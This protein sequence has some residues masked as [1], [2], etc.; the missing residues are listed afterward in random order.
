MKIYLGGFP[1][2]E[3]DCEIGDVLEELKRY[4]EAGELE[5]GKAFVGIENEKHHILNIV[6]LKNEEFG[7][8]AG[9]AEKR[10]LSYEQVKKIIEDFFDGKYPEWGK[11]MKRKDFEDG[12]DDILDGEW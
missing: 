12:I 10:G 6:K 7:V 11:N 1:Y 3:V 4:P 8:V 9:D 2:G 5:D